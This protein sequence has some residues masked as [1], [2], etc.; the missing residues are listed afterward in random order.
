MPNNSSFNESSGEGVS[1]VLQLAQQLQGSGEQEA[2]Q[3]SV[4]ETLGEAPGSLD[5]RT[6]INLEQALRVQHSLVSGHQHVHHL[7]CML[8][9][10]LRNGPLLGVRAACPD[11]CRQMPSPLQALRPVVG[12][13]PGKTSP[14][15]VLYSI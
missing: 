1:H 10:Y 5:R 9:L 6:V 7:L 11:L 15:A 14:S 13:S 2:G 3:G 4:P 12:S 8:K